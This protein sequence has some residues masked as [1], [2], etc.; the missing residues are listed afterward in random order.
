MRKSLQIVLCAA[1]LLAAACTH[2]IHDVYVSS[3]DPYREYQNGKYIEA[4][5]EQHTILGFVRD[6]QY[7]DQAYADL[8]AQC[9]SGEIRGIVT[10]FSTSHGFFSWTNKIL[11]KGYCFSDATARKG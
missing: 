4:R 3:F 10:Q 7:V 2:S 11:M 5:T 8:N 6:T 1:V 9:R